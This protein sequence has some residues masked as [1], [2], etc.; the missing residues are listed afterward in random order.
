MAAFEDIGAD[1]PYPPDT[2]GLTAQEMRRLG[3]KIVDIVVDRLERRHAE[4]AVLTGRPDDLMASLGGRL[5][6]NPGSA[7]EAIDLL[8][9]VALANQQHGDHPRYF[10]R[11]PSPAAFAAVLGDWLGIGYNTIATSWVG[12][13]GPA[14]L[15]LVAL[16][17]LREFL[18]LPDEGDGILVSGG[19]IANLTALAA[20]RTAGGVGTVYLT[21]QAHSSLIRA[22]LL[23]G[24]GDNQIRVIESDDEFKMPMDRLKATVDRDW[25][26]GRSPRIVIGSAGTTNTGSIDPLADMADLCKFHNLWFHIDGAYGATAAAS[27]ASRDSLAG[28]EH[29][30]SLVIDPHKWLFQPYGLGCT[31]VR[32]KGALEKAFS[33]SPEYL[34][35]T[36]SHSGETS[37]GNRG[38][39][40][41]RRSRAI[42]LWLTFR[43]YGAERI[44][45]GIERGI[46]IAQYAER[47]LRQSPETWDVVTAARLGIVTFARQGARASEHEQSVKQLTSSG[48]ATATTTVLKGRSVLRLCTI[49]PLTTEADIARTIN[50]LAASDV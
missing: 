5:P 4:P 7:D 46:A 19:S 31:L 12:G 13:S 2:L 50:M 14:T 24:F 29:A 42:K 36:A 3:H 10:S 48:V 40:L 28:I 11:V 23:L 45:E 30:D 32:R 22:L 41:T 18:G 17:W 8:A 49:N 38:P 26:E 43:I 9:S 27:P 25:R 44:R 21:D 16:K 15:E 6:S 47:F 33:M 34:K 39:E 20:A 37:F 1:A 35:D